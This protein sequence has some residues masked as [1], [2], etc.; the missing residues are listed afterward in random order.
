[1]IEANGKEH[2]EGKKFVLETQ[3]RRELP[4]EDGIQ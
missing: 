3:D 2:V 1:M 4:E